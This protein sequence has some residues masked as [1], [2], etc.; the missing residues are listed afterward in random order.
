[1]PGTVKNF[2]AN[3]QP[4]TVK[5]ERRLNVQIG[6]VGSSERNAAPT[7]ATLRRA[8]K[9]AVVTKKI[10]DHHM[11]LEHVKS[12]NEQVSRT[13]SSRTA[14]P[15]A[16]VIGAGNGNID[17]RTTLQNNHAGMQ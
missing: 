8:E 17:H 9:T 12:G 3:T 7:Y 11:V 16:C 6:G 5:S 14:V 13:F 1:M 10:H 4:V 15:A 2:A